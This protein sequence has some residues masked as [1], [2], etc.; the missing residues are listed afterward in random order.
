MR[1]LTEVCL[2]SFCLLA[3]ISS[4]SMQKQI[5]KQADKDM[6]NDPGFLPAHVGISLYDPATHQYLY[7][8][9]GD[10]FFIPASNMKLFTCYEA[11]KNLGDSLISVWY[12]D[13]GNGTIEV[14]ANGDA[15]FLQ[16]DFKN[17]PVYNLL[18]KQKTV[19]LTDDNW[20]E[21]ALGAGWAWDDYNS[22][23]MAERSVMPI[24]G[25]L[26]RFTQTKGFSASPSYF[27]KK[28][29]EE[30]VA[31]AK[32]R[33]IIRRQF[34]ADSFVV[35][36]SINRFVSA[37]IPFYTTGN[38]TLIQLLN[39]TLK[40]N[41]ELVHAKLNRTPATQK[42][43]S[44]ST[45]SLLKIMMHRSDNFFA[46][47]TLLMLSNEI[48]GMMNN[49]R[50]ID[51]LLKTDLAGLPQKPRW[52]DGSGLSR[53]NLVSPQDMVWILAQMKNE[54]KWERI[55]SILPTG[56]EGTLSGLYKNYEGRIY[57]KT[58]TLSNHV[59]LSGYITT[60]S[61]RQLIFSVLVNAHQTTAANI[62]KGVEKFLTAV[63]DKY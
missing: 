24:Y 6:L 48:L 51:T 3:L 23:Y 13:K 61:G 2:L 35:R 36:P 29:L 28:S 12:N 27:Q 31:D 60:K 4:C 37:D 50:I 63:M 30:A 8:H 26:A 52:M 11:M 58:G 32:E 41:V 25:N 39:D 21:N 38:K 10:K 33:F 14:E 7:N 15:S 54:F 16:P 59:A 57:A 34:F 44:Q 42:I 17:Q 47:Q 40:N 53:Y 5:A 56:G 62:R 20:K 22:D 18:K 1:K 19:L 49:G 43:Y 46:E 9:Q 45:D 55:T